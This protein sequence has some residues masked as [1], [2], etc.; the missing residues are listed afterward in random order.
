LCLI[1]NLRDYTGSFDREYSE[2]KVTFSL[3]PLL[4]YRWTAVAIF[5]TSDVWI[6]WLLVYELDIVSKPK[7]LSLS[8]GF[9]N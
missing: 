4:R 7:I 5:E 6:H 9:L 8:L 2:R 1:D 3:S